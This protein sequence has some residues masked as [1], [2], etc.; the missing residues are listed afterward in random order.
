MLGRHHVAYRVTW[1][2]LSQPILRRRGIST[3]DRIDRND[4]IFFG[5]ESL[6]RAD[7]G[8]EGVPVTHRP[9]HQKD[10]IIPPGIELAPGFVSD[11]QLG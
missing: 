6:A 10:R 4:E 9:V 7:R 3:A 11:S 2:I 1:E 5:I 8:I